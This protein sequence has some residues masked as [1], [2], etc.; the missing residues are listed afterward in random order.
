MKI[1]IG[2]DTDAHGEVNV[3]LV[4]LAKRTGLPLLAPATEADYQLYY[5]DAAL[6]LQDNTTSPPVSVTIDFCAGNNRH[7]QQFGGGLG[8]PVARAVNARKLRNTHQVICD[9]TGGFGGDAFV[10]ASL[11]CRVVL[12]ERSVIVYELLRDAMNRA[13]HNPETEE[14]IK[15][16]H[17]HCTDSTALPAAWPETP[18]PHTIYLDPMYPDSGKSAAAKKQMQTLKR[19]LG[20]TRKNAN[21]DERLL[22][23]AVNTATHRVVVKRPKS[24]APIAGPA[25]VGEIRSA[26]TR[27]D[28]YHPIGDV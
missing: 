27:Y 8:Q 7:R 18:R 16:M 1:R 3:Q 12:L 28:I 4:E 20:T 14:I 9:A 26:N 19:L 23:A 22:A 15:R 17:V 25:P 10:F 21:N 6:T 24:A 2:A 5:D 13:R 11:G